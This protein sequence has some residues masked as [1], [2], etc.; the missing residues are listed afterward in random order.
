MEVQERGRTPGGE[1][2]E[3]GGQTY[4]GEAKKGR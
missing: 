3:G 1:K 4:K 2:R